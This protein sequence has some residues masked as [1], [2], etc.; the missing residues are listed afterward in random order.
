MLS[1]AEE[2]STLANTSTAGN[3]CLALEY[4]EALFQFQPRN[5]ETCSRSSV[6]NMTIPRRIDSDGSCYSGFTSTIPMVDDAPFDLLTE[7]IL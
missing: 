6:F 7:V 2:Q 5:R 4:N 3:R 1:T